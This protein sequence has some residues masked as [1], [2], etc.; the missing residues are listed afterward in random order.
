MI[1]QQ[2]Q[3]SFTIDRHSDAAEKKSVWRND[4]HD[5]IFLEYVQS[6]EARIRQLELTAQQ[7]SVYCLIINCLM[8]QNCNVLLFMCTCSTTCRI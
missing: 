5:N 1:S 6:L 3:T 4:G 2:M 8:F 7:D